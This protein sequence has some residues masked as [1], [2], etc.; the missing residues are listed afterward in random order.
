MIRSSEDD[1][2]MRGTLDGIGLIIIL[3]FGGEGERGREKR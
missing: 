1:E 3:F 2:R